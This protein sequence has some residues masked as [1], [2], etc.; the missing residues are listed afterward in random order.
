[1]RLLKEI[2]EECKNVRLCQQT[3]KSLQ[4]LFAAPQFSIQ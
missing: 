1:M 4:N 3:V 2:V